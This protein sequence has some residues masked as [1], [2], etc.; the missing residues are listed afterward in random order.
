MMNIGFVPS[1]CIHRSIILIFIEKK[2]CF[3]IFW[4][5]GG[6]GGR[7]ACDG[8]KMFSAIFDFHFHKSP[9][10]CDKFQA[11]INVWMY[12]FH[13]SLAYQSYNMH[14]T[15]TYMTKMLQVYTNFY[16]A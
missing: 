10:F 3:S 1:I 15:G 9:C 16:P 6:G 11:L 7:G 4:G 5:A 2:V 8:K 14:M 12:C 13:T